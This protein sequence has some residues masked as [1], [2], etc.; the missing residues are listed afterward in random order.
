M[1]IVFCGGGTAGHVTPN[2]ALIEKLHDH[3]IYYFGSNGME[4]QLTQ[5]LVDN[6][7]ISQFCQFEASKLARKI[8]LSNLKLPF[9][10]A[11]S[12]RQCKKYL[13]EISPN[14]V[15]SKGG[16]V[17]LPVVIASKQLKIPTIIHESDM[18]MGLANKISS[19]FASKCLMTFGNHKKFT[20][21]GAI[22][23]QS[24]L[25]G[26]KQKGLETMGFA[27]KRPILLVMGGSLG[28]NT[29]NNAICNTP[30]LADFFD[31]FL[32]TGKGKKIDCPFVHQKEYVTNIAD[33]FSATSVCLT[34]AGSNSLVELTLANIPFVTVPLT[35]CSRGEQIKNAKWFTEKGCGFLLQEKDIADNLYYALCSA[36]FNRNAIILKQQQL[37]Y[38]Y[39]TD[40]VVDEILAYNTKGSQS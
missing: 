7:T 37:N 3:Q 34:R 26:N 29:L 21:T 31:I 14:V 28:A 30:K 12:V 17:G 13:K 15:F 35:K 18:S 6:G 5:K 39:G 22:I 33:V 36:Y 10:L 25:T 24:V 11:K 38:L 16:Y 2:L 20:T 19:K 4:K 9:S 1:R 40:K 27:G 8:T 32:I 23:R